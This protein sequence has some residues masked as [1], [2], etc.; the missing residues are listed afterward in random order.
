MMDKSGGY[1]RGG[2]IRVRHQ[3]GIRG[4]AILWLGNLHRGREQQ[5]VIPLLLVPDEAMKRPAA[6]AD[7]TG[8][9]PPRTTNSM[10]R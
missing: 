8:S 7:V 9:S 3:P 2:R 4:L 6:I 10:R 5:R 1:R